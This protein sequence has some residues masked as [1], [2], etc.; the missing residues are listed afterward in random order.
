MHVIVAFPG[1]GKTTFVK[2][3]PQ[4]EDLETKS[5]DKTH[6]PANL[7]D[8]VAQRVAANALTVISSYH[9]AIPKALDEAKIPFY[10]AFP[11]ERARTE[12]HARYHAVNPK[13]AEQVANNWDTWMA[14]CQAQ[15][16]SH[17]VLQEHLFLTDLLEV[18]NDQFVTKRW[19]SFAE[20]VAGR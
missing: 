6:F 9:E 11:V 5:F 19:R 1:T 15:P 14:T 13:F 4:V 18:V 16:G 20:I 7:V 17:V 8:H 2:K 3:Y 10:M 12:Y